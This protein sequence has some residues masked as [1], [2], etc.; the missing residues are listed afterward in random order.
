MKK[1]KRISL[2]VLI[3]VFIISPLSAQ[4]DL[5]T[6]GQ[7]QYDGQNYSLVWDNDSPFGSIVWLDYTNSATTWQNQMN[8]ASGLNDV[9][10]LTYNIDPM[11]SIE[12]SGN[13]RL[14]G[15]VDS[16]AVYGYDGTTT[17]GY[18]ITNSELG[19]LFYTELG[20]KG[21][22]STTG[23]YQPDYGL[24]DTGDFQQLLPGIY[25]SRQQ[26]SI[27]PSYTWVFDTSRGL[28]TLASPGYTGA[29]AVRFG[30]VVVVPEPLSSILFITGG[31]L[32]AERRLLRR[33]A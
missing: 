18:N 31:M 8:W 19:H 23:V 25:W 28:Q 16:L 33:K 7:A 29:I 6:I 24:T 10:V 11:Y 27:N 20:N 1:R 22:Y 26:Y 12:W 30:D 13:W 5:T 2:I 21:Y 3:T 17:Q 32:L 9:G 4:A 15:T 14:P